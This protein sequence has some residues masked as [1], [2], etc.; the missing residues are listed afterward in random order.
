MQ[1]T[2]QRL[3]IVYSI[4]GPL[5]YASVLDIGR[6]WERLLH[7]ARITLAFSKGFNPHPRMQFAAA[8]PVGYTS[9]CEVL[10]V[11]VAQEYDPYLVLDQLKPQ[12]PQGLSIQQVVAV[13]LAA[14][15]PQ[16]TLMRMDFRILVSSQVTVAQFESKIASLL[17][18]PS[19]IFERTR[20]GQSRP[21]DL[22][23]LILSL[24][25]LNSAENVHVVELSLGVRADGSIRPEEVLSALQIPIMRLQIH[26][27]GLAWLETEE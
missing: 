9:S 25:Y 24:K 16:A 7:R 8:L 14:P 1:P 2:S 11:W 19:F 20:K 22:R 10:D 6:L 23:P 27:T 5:S 18:A 17:A 4:A 21:F 26:R 3:R 13:P 12:C 15:S